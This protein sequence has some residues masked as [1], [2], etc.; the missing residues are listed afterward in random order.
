M[1]SGGECSKKRREDDEAGRWEG[2]LADLCS[3][4]LDRADTLDVIRFLAV[5][6]EW[7]QHPSKRRW[8]T[9]DFAC[10]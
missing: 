8:V 7:A 1:S 6:R 10:R 5:C 9:D 3:M 2:L 4:V